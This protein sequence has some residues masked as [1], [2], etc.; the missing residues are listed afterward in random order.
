MMVVHGIQV[1]TIF[2]GS[3][4]AMGIS[5]TDDKEENLKW[6][7]RLDY[8]G[9]QCYEDPYPIEKEYPL[10]TSLDDFTLV[11]LLNRENTQYSINRVEALKLAAMVD[12]G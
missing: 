7:N 11:H 5:E 3:Q 10:E 9:F 8:R 2:K 1:S 6:L 12:A 4:K